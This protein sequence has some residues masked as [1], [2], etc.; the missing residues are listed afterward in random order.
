MVERP[1][2]PASV[3]H[4]F[5]Y[6]TLV[7]G[8][9]FAYVLAGIAGQWTPAVLRGRVSNEGWAARFG[10]P[11]LVPDENGV[12]VGGLVLSSAALLQ[13]WDRLDK[14]EEVGY[15]R[16]IANATLQGGTQVQAHVYA[17]RYG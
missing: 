7:P 2:A 4:L 8:K 17:L 6:G 13:H 1:A 12:E 16:R 9:P 3:Q 5:V 15:R 10:Y 14:F 11:G